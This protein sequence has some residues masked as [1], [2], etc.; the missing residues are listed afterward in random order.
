MKIICINQVIIFYEIEEK[1][2][3]FEFLKDKK[4]LMHNQ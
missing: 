4:M 2:G 1:Q 3:L